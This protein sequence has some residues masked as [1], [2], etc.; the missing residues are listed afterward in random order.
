MRPS[1]EI[2]IP[3]ACARPACVVDETGRLR[4]VSCR[5]GDHATISPQ[6]T[7]TFGQGKRD[8]RHIG[9]FQCEGHQRAVH[10][11][12]VGQAWSVTPLRL[13]AL[14]KMLLVHKSFR[15]FS[16]VPR[17]IDSEH[18]A[19]KPKGPCQLYKV[20]ACAKAD[21]R[22]LLAP[23]D[24]G[25]REGAPPD[26]PLRSPSEHVVMWGDPTVE[27][28]RLLFRLPKGQYVA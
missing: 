17:K 24:S 3:R 16:R 7:A 27:R 15:A 11:V 10:R 28:M 6:N 8:L 20:V 5:R 21:F 1:S 26:S 13:W 23:P 18:G 14:K 25:C 4:G 19:D 9:R 12:R 22:Y 2:V